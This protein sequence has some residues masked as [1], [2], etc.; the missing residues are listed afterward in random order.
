M[1]AVINK[2]CDYFTDYFTNC[3]YIEIFEISEN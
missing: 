2:V 3:F 1:K